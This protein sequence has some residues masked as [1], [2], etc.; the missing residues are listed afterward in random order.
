M[1][2]SKRYVDQIDARLK[3][4][5]EQATQRP[6]EPPRTVRDWT[7]PWPPIRLSDDEWVLMRDSQTEPAAIVRRL[8]M[9]PRQQTYYRVVSWAPNSENRKLVGYFQTLADADRSV[10]FS[11]PNPSMP[12]VRRA[13]GH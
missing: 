8:K 10:L 12:D 6:P 1:G 13:S 4:R 2:T 7:P 3:A 11:P 9:G 5:V